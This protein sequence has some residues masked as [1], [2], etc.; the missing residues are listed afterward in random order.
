MQGFEGLCSAGEV[1]VSGLSVGGCVLGE[2]LEY[3]IRSQYAADFLLNP[4]QGPGIVS[5]MY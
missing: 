3:N 1:G 5:D 4:F 2:E